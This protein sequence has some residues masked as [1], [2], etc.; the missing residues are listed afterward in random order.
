MQQFHSFPSIEQFRTVIKYVNDR[1]EHH[2]V[3]IKPKLQFT[4]TVKL[5]GTN[6]GVVVKGTDVYCQSRTSVVTP[7]NDNAGFATF[8]MANKYRF[9]NLAC[10]AAP[11]Q[12]VALYG[13]WI[14]KGIQKGVAIAQLEKR[15][16]LFAVRLLGADDEHSVWLKPSEIAALPVGTFDDKICSI[17]QFP[18]WQVT[19]DFGAPGASQ[20]ALVDITMAVEQECPVGKAL[21]VSGIGEGVVWTCEDSQELPFKTSDLL[22]KVKGPKHS[23]TKTKVLV[24]V[25][26]ERMGKI[27][28]LA[29]AVTTDHRLE[30]G[31]DQLR[32]DNPGVDILDMTMIPQFLK[33]VGQD[34]LKEEVDLIKANGFEV[35][36]VTKAV[37]GFART[38]FKNLVDKIE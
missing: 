27:T 14:G 34:V 11:A 19:I 16:V 23:D 13:E 1:C 5:H 18:T 38:W 32:L 7:E 6:S 10:L 37:N 24:P 30:K 2:R 31:L 8:V 4:G 26:V 21:G 22:F 12:D 15:F 29:K 25:D 17:Y 28:D 9:L 20:N 3:P 33:W 36:D 35:K